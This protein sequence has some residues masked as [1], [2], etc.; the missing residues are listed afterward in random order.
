M[1]NV[2]E[3]D[4]LVNRRRILEEFGKVQTQIA[5]KPN[6][7]RSVAFRVHKEL[8]KVLGDDCIDYPEF[9]FWFSRLLQGNFDLNYDR[10]YAARI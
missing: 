4:S 10:R 3:K 9:E 2:T 5:K 7:W 6:D 1:I 8:S